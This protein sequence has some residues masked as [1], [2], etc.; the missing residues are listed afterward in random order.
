VILSLNHLRGD[1][2]SIRTSPE[3]GGVRAVPELT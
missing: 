2:S 1:H 3:D